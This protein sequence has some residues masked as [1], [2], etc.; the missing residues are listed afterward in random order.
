MSTTENQITPVDRLKIVLAADSVQ[1][2]FRNALK[3]SA[4]A[5][6]ASILDIYAGD[7][8]LQEC[9]PAD[10]VK[11]ALKG[12]ILNLPLVKSLAYA[13]IVPR[14]QKDVWMP[15][16]Q[17]GWRGYIQLALRTKQYKFINV[18]EV[19]E[20]EYVQ[21]NKL[22]GEFD[23]TGMPTSK[24]VIGYFAYFELKDG[25]S[26]TLYMTVPEIHQHGAKFS[27]SYTK[28]NSK[29]KTD[30]PS[31]AK[32]T[33]VRGLLGK[34]GILSVEMAEAFESD[35]DEVADEVEAKA[36]KEKMDFTEAVVVPTTGTQPGHTASAA[37]GQQSTEGQPAVTTSGQ[38][39]D[40]SG[41]ANGGDADK[42]KS[43]P[44][45]LPF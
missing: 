28:E 4:P 45:K 41:P 37:P 2:Q 6:L 39:M 14:R 19:L 5:F 31:M 8:Y 20:G 11:Q 25:Y 21:R 29:W 43:G 34:W 3:D 32:K 16:F 44:D 15:V 9:N 18:D 7:N 30:F 17:L 26:K 10:V 38:A 24:T 42:T 27:P 36:N 1:Q 40:F 23:L 12:A 13:H 22:T 35:I 33:M